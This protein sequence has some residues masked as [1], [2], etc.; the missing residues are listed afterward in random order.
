V[1]VTEFGP[2]CVEDTR[3]PEPV[4]PS[5]PAVLSVLD[6]TELRWFVPGPLPSWVGS[7]F[8][9]STGVLSERRDTYLL[10]GRDDIGVKR[11]FRETLEVKVRQSLDGPIEFGEGLGGSLEAW[12]RWSPAEGLVDA[13]T[14]GQWVDVSKSIV[15]RRFTKDGI[16]TF[17]SS[18]AQ[19]GAAGCDVEVAEVTVGAVE[20]WTFAFAAFGPRATGLD[21]LV[22]SWLGLVSIGPCTKSFGPNVGR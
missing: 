18:E 12:R 9:G 17:F 15:K 22:A 4:R 3:C 2:L 11:R 20:S 13:G 1:A 8:T 19:L 10:G 5:C 14:G 21:A 6:T 7:W 16:E